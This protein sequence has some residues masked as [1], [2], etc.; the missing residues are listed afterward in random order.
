MAVLTVELLFVPLELQYV[1]HLTY[2]LGYGFVWSMAQFRQI[3]DIAIRW[4]IVSFEIC[5]TT[6]LAFVAY[7]VIPRKLREAF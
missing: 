5:V 1:D 4:D 3:G 2:W 7:A 6:T